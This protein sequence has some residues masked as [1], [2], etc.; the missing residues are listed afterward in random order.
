MLER[1]NQELKRRI[2]KTRTLY[3]R[4]RW[5]VT[6]MKIFLVRSNGHCALANGSFLMRT[7][8]DAIELHVTP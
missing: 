3:A 6:Q 7:V 4:S 8:N 5:L 1:I 2:N